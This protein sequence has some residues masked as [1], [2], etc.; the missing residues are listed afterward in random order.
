M[1]FQCFLCQTEDDFNSLCQE[2]KIHLVQSDQAPSQSLIT[3]CDDRPSNWT[4][5]STGNLSASS[6]NMA[7]SLSGMKQSMIFSYILWLQI[8]FIFYY[9]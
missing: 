5:D 3:I 4:L 8:F 6:D 9:S 2:L 1:V 7:V